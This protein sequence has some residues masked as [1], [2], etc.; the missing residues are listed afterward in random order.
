[1][2]LSVARPDDGYERLQAS[3]SQNPAFS[4]PRALS[5]LLILMLWAT[6]YFAGMFSP[7]LLDDADSVHAEAA[8]E[9]L[10]RHDWATLY[11]N[12]VRYLEKAPLLYW[13]I[14][15]SYEAFGVSD[16]SSRLPLMLGVLALLLATYALGSSAF[17]ERAGLYSALALGTAIGPYIFTRFL[18]PDILIGLWLTLGVHCFLLSLRKDRPSL[19]ACWGFAA[20]CALSVLTKGL[21]GLVFPFG[22]VGGYLLLTGDW[23]HLL[24]LRLV[25]ST[26]VFLALAAPWHVIA[27]IRNPSQGDVRGFLWFYFVNEHFRRFIGTRVPP[28]YDTVP[29]GIFWALLI[30]WLL[31]W[32]AFLPQALR[33]VPRHIREWRSG[34]NFRGQAQLVC[35][36]WILVIVGFFSFSTRQEYYT[37]PAVPAMALLVGAWLGRESSSKEGSLERR[38]G[39][40]SSVGLLVFGAV[41]CAVGLYLFAVSTPPSAGADLADLLKKNPQDYDFSLGHVLDLTP[42]A[43]G[44]FRA[45]LLGTSLALLLGGLLNWQFRRK[46]QME[47]GNAALV[48]MMVVVLTCVHSAFVTFSPILSSQALA[49]AIQPYYR[50]GDIV[51]VDGQYHRASTLNF[52]LGAPLRIV[53][54]PSGNLWYGV[55]FPDA[56]RVF[57]TAASLRALWT[58]PGRVFLWTENDAP[59]VIEG[60]SSYLLA[61]NGGK[62]IFSN[63]PLSR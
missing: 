48:G 25:S 12:G 46:G 53:H 18:I 45:P 13:G 24:K 20:T 35:V 62:Y 39:M 40:R 59:K 38:A 16:W 29:L 31:P 10:T 22:I 30:A 49:A 3:A 41:A 19:L 17:D 47:R 52:Y 36:L 33:D 26:L 37:L 9:M 6:V 42:R 54:E 50:A 14:A 43:L 15:V 34:L 60:L 21:I 58:A 57:E 1:M 8:R 51:A 5:A 55:K 63:Q 32:S 27:A 7:A 44:A 28:G 11:T 61:H 2:T 4:R 23:R 56:P